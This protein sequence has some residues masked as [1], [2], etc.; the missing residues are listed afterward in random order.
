M[1]VPEDMPL[2][3]ARAFLVSNPEALETFCERIAWD[4]ESIETDLIENV[5]EDE[6]ERWE[7]IEWDELEE[8][9]E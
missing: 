2:V 8:A 5:T 3:K 4:K 9:A 7:P 6:A 1:A